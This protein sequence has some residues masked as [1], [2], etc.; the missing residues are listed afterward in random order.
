MPTKPAL[1]EQHTAKPAHTETIRLDLLDLS[2]A[3]AARA[4]RQADAVKAY[5][6]CYRDEGSAALPPI[7]VFRSDEVS[8][9]IFYLADGRHRV[10]A[11]FKAQLDALPA[12]VHD[13]DRR[14]ATLY[15]AG[16]NAQHGARMTIE[17]KRAVVTTLLMDDEWVLWS[18]RQLADTAHV[19]PQ[20][21][22]KMRKSLKRHA[23]QRTGKDGTVR[24]R[25]NSRAKAAAAK[26]DQAQM[27][28][29]A[30][31]EQSAQAI[32]DWVDTEDRAMMN[33][34][35][36][37]RIPESL[38]EELLQYK[39]LS[40]MKR[41][42]LLTIYKI[43]HLDGA[44]DLVDTSRDRLTAILGA[45]DVHPGQLRKE[46]L[47]S[48]VKLNGQVCYELTP[49]GRDMI[50]PARQCHLDWKNLINGLGHAVAL[51]EATV[52][53]IPVPPPA[54]PEPPTVRAH[55]VLTRPAPND[56]KLRGLIAD[57]LRDPKC[58]NILDDRQT[59]LLA[60]IVGMNSNAEL[61]WSDD[62]LKTSIALFGEDLR[63]GIAE[64]VI[65]GDPRLPDLQHLCHLFMLDHHALTLIAER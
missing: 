11:A 54:T 25:T 22:A 1:L 53:D 61:R 62:A 48:D 14:A 58:R 39:A 26:D 8:G 16:A 60:C 64:A 34:A 40:D 6:E 29:E 28:L 10:E 24:A 45:L 57:R 9:E 21:V 7:V 5:T 3:K 63:A 20:L 23:E 43:V 27:T 18:D 56:A 2:I 38:R 17:D 15:A 52:E 50:A 51:S 35:P 30:D 33:A 46:G 37:D 4:A 36:D 19:S 32:W 47:I 49:L 59:C 65:A 42:I 55:D 44:E 31:A 13:G 41:W 12:I